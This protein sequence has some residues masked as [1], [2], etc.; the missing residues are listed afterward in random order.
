MDWEWIGIFPIEVNIIIVPIIQIFAIM[1][2]FRDKL[3]TWKDVQYKGI[4]FNLKNCVTAVA[5]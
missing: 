1:A 5:F 4:K 3:G 2:V